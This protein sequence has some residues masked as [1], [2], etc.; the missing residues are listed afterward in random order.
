MDT[1]HT[2]ILYAQIREKFLVAQTH[3][4]CMTPAHPPTNQSTRPTDPPPNLSCQPATPGN[5]RWSPPVSEYREAKGEYKLHSAAKPLLQCMPPPEA[6][7]L[8]AGTTQVGGGA[9]ALAKIMVVTKHG[10]QLLLLGG[11]QAW[12]LP[13]GLTLV[14]E[15]SSHCKFNYSFW[16]GDGF[17]NPAARAGRWLRDGGSTAALYHCAMKH[18]LRPCFL[19]P[20]PCPSLPATAAHCVSHCLFP[21]LCLPRC[22]SKVLSTGRLSPTLAITQTLALERPSTAQRQQGRVPLTV[23]QPHPQL[24]SSTVSPDDVSV[25]NQRGVTNGLATVMEGGGAAGGGEEGQQQEGGGGGERGEASPGRRTGEGLGFG[26]EAAARGEKGVTIASSAT[27]LGQKDGAISL[28][29]RAACAGEGR[30]LRLVFG[31]PHDP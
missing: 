20:T 1:C 22:G 23:L 29:V 19:S 6:P 17:V 10:S 4:A 26:S 8:T 24:G 28:K 18:A 25:T 9:G 21:T 16:L 5:A 2:G 12:A 14:L 7:E 31:M 15:K 11:I 3:P 30:C 27:V 13:P